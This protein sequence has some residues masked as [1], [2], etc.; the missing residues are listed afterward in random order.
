MDDESAVARIADAID[1]GEIELIIRN[2]EQGQRLEVEHPEE[3]SPELSDAFVTLKGEY[4]RTLERIA[5][6]D[7][8]AAAAVDDEDWP[9]FREV[10]VDAAEVHPDALESSRE[11]AADSS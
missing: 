1:A 5:G 9:A 2:V 8:S 6:G 11:A 10:A 3:L 4:G 7:L